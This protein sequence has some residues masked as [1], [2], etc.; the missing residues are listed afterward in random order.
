[1]TSEK[2]YEMVCRMLRAFDG[3]S[4]LGAAE[5]VIANPHEW[6]NTSL[7]PFYADAAQL[8]IDA[9]QE[10]D[11]K[12]T[13]AAQLAALN[14]VIKNVPDYREG[15]KGLLPS[16]DRWAVC[17]GYRFIRVQNKPESIPEA[18]NPMELDLDKTVPQGAKDGGEITLPSVAQIKASIA[19]LRAKHGRDWQRHPMEAVPGWWCNAQYLL[20]MVQALPGGVAYQPKNEY[21]PMYY[22]SAEGDAVLLPVRHSA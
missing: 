5:Q 7:F 18:K 16:G 3:A 4:D 6:A 11:K 15:L 19:N 9:M 8:L 12:T 2:R 20:D 1:M 22:E 17:D 21:T 10:M 14:R 13:P